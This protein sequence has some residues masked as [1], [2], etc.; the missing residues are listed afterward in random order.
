MKH[1]IEI[2]GPIISNDEVWIY[3][4]FEM[5]ATSPRMVGEELKKANGKDVIVSINSPGGYVPDGSEV[6][7]SLK[8]YKGDVEVQIVGLAASAASVIAMSGSKVRISPTAQLM[9]H[10]AS[11]IVAGDYRTMDGASEMLKTTN[12]TIANAYRIKS[13]LGEDELL[14]L[15]NKETWMS[16]QDALD[17]GFVDEIMFANNAFKV[18]AFTD[19]SGMIPQ[20]VVA[21]IRNKT[22]NENKSTKGTKTKNQSSILDSLMKVKNKGDD[23]H[24]AKNDWLF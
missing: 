21:G 15:M 8:N 2:T 14:D 24:E 17:K 3:E 11:G 7:T 18:A 1:N 19:A 22:V 10:N 13:G 4:L 12:K 6:Y 9:I 5:D 16:P 20:E 23:K